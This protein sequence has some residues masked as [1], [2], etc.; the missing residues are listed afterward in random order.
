MQIEQSKARILADCIEGMAADAEDKGKDSFGI[1][2]SLKDARMIARSLSPT[3]DAV[4]VVR[5][6][7]CKFWMPE[8]IERDDS[9]IMLY[10]QL[11]WMEPGMVPIEFGVNV[12]SYCTLCENVITHGFRDGNPSLD[13][14]RLW[15]REDDYCS[16][17]QR[18]DQSADVRNM[19]GGNEHE[20]AR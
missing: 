20:C 16:R 4:P 17:G 2:L 12:G 9:S 19:E 15:R 18:R 6:R 10:E 7:E 5:C 3:V 8:H 1:H 13:C 11:P 14:T